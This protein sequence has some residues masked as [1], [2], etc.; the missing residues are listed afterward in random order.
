MHAA[1]SV[2]HAE[3]QRKQQETGCGREGRRGLYMPRVAFMQAWPGQA[4]AARGASWQ[5]PWLGVPRRHWLAAGSR[6]A[7]TTKV[8]WLHQGGKGRCRIRLQAQILHSDQ[9]NT[10][11]PRLAETPQ[12]AV[13]PVRPPA[14]PVQLKVLPLIGAADVQWT[15]EAP[16]AGPLRAP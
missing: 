3:G 5:P 11:A 7:Q 13:L 8:M 1:D 2:L 10:P 16:P 14:A 4:V 6:L 15:L 9:R 12:P